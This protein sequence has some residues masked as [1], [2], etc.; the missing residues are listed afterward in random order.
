ME[1]S[2]YVALSRQIALN[3]NLSIIANN[4]ANIN[5]PGFRGQNLIFEEYVS[6]PRGL[7]EPLSL[8]LDYGQYQVTDPGPV[9]VTGG[10][11][12]AAL[13]GP[14]F[15]GVQT[16]NGVQY[17]RAGNF[18]L[19]DTG[20]LVTARG[21]ALAG[22]GGGDIIIPANATEISIDEN[23]VISTDQGQVGQ[24]SVFEF[25]SDQ[26]LIPEG[27]GLYSAP[28]PGAPAQNTRVKQGM[29]ENSNVQ[30]VVEM[31]RL[32]EV[33]R[34]YQALQ[35][36]IQTEHDRQRAAVQRLLQDTRA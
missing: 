11:L 7:K 3:E 5:T 12:D 21:F 20:T 14:G 9:S 15:F 33:S 22:S 36:M 29:L 24:L 35:R 32:I 34:E 19:T 4:V 6:D 8:V 2:L 16:P 18:T 26:V 13:E 27:N 28:Q 10:P 31:T 17:T 25:E 1:N 30:G 23:G